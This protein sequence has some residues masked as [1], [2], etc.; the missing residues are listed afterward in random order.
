MK[1]AAKSQHPAI[2]PKPETD[3]ARTHICTVSAETNCLTVFFSKLF[4]PTAIFAFLDKTD[5][6]HYRIL[7]NTCTS[8]FR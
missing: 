6:L 7:Q 3:F 5:L 8:F 4:F 1:R 2:R